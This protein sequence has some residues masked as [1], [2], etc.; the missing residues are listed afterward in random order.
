MSTTPRRV[1]PARDTQP[2]ESDPVDLNKQQPGEGDDVP[3]K[4]NNDDDAS[5]L[6]PLVEA[7]AV[8]AA[9][10]IAA[11]QAKKEAESARR[12]GCFALFVV[13]ALLGALVDACDGDDEANREQGRQ[14]GSTLRG[15]S[16]ST[17]TLEQA[18]KDAAR[19]AG[20]SAHGDWADGC[21][22]AA[23]GR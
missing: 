11:H 16:R 15:T 10:G 21:T 12:A 8:V 2:S 18:C 19:A 23:T 7:A 4:D 6:H 5:G 14:Y 20:H 13:L 9:V 1:P 17:Y 3:D 22:S